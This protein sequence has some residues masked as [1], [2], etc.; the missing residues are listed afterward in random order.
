MTFNSSN[1]QT[2][3]GFTVNTIADTGDLHDDAFVRMSYSSSH[4]NYDHSRLIEFDIRD[5]DA[6]GGAGSETF[7]AD[8]ADLFWGRHTAFTCEG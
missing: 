5:D 8:N 2:N 1:W 7:L 6:P 3:Q 4:G